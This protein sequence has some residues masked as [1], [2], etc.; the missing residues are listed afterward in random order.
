MKMYE[1]A[2]EA[3]N[4]SEIPGMRDLYGKWVA[5]KES[6]RLKNG[7]ARSNRYYQHLYDKFVVVILVRG[8]YGRNGDFACNQK[9]QQATAKL[10]TEGW[11]VDYRLLDCDK[12]ETVLSATSATQLAAILKNAVPN[13]GTYG[14]F[15]WL[16]QHFQV[17]ERKQLHEFKFAILA[18]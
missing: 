16:D 15:F 8:R 1:A 7:L 17:V 9:M 10:E 4:A 11:R 5:M 6:E 14:P 18:A 3:K 12:A 13:E 2:T